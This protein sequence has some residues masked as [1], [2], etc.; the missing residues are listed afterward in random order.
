M[1]V[2]HLRMIHM[3]HVIHMIVVIGQRRPQCARREQQDRARHQRGTARGNFGYLTQIAR[4]LVRMGL[5]HKSDIIAAPGVHTRPRIPRRDHARSMPGI[6]T[7]T[8]IAKRPSY[9][10][11]ME[12]GLSLFLPIREAEY[13]CGGV[14]RHSRELPD[15][16]IS[17]TKMAR[18]IRL[19]TIFAGHIKTRP[20]F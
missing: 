20:A 10:G 12:L 14:D 7:L 11:W 13:F 5:C 15:W 19:V 6:S 3:V 17:Q 2:R 1:P 9:R 8:K 18:L 4:Q 16:Q